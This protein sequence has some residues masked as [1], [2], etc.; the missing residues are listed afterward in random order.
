VTGSDI[1][2]TTIYGFDASD[3]TS[4]D[5]IT[6]AQILGDEGVNVV[7]T[8]TLNTNLEGLWTELNLA[9]LGGGID[10]AFSRFNETSGNVDINNDGA[11]DDNLGVLAYDSDDVGITSL[12]FLDNYTGSFGAEDIFST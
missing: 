3:L 1:Q 12:V 11:L 9:L 7:T 10:L 2:F 8:G 5:S 6:F 4:A